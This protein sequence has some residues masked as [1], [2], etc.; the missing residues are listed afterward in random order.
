MGLRVSNCIWRRPRQTATSQQCNLLLSLGKRPGSDCE[1][2]DVRR[3]VE[4][5]GSLVWSEASSGNYGAKGRE[6]LSSL[7][8]RG[9]LTIDMNSPISPAT[10]FVAKNG[11]L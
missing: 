4:E 3:T 9:V 10:E 8:L 6:I 1:W 11:G 5:Q 2:E 7:L